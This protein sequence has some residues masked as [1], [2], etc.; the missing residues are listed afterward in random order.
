M[1]GHR[2][3]TWFHSWPM[4]HVKHK[5]WHRQLYWKQYNTVAFV[6]YYTITDKMSSQIKC[7]HVSALKS[8]RK[9]LWWQQLWQ[10]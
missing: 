8:K 10:I 3:G 5:P 6:K 2:L 1:T 7:L 4:C 9:E